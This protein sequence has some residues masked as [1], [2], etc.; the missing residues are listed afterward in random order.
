MGAKIFSIE[1]PDDAWPPQTQGGVI[2][3]PTRPTW[4]GSPTVPFRVR[5][6]GLFPGMMFTLQPPNETMCS[7]LW[8][9]NRNFSWV[10]APF[11]N[12]STSDGH[13]CPDG[14]CINV[15]DAPIPVYPTMTV[16][17]TLTTSETPTEEAT[18]TLSPTLS[19]TDTESQS[20]TASN[21]ISPTITHT[22]KPDEIK[23]EPP[24]YYGF[25]FGG[26]RAP[27]ATTD[28]NADGTEAIFHV[29]IS[30]YLEQSVTGLVFCFQPPQVSMTP[31]PLNPNR[32]DINFTMTESLWPPIV[33][34]TID[35][36]IELQLYEIRTISGPGGIRTFVNRTVGTKSSWKVANDQP[37]YSIEFGSTLDY[38]MTAYIPWGHLHAAFSLDPWCG[39]LVAP[40]GWDPPDGVSGSSW[41]DDPTLPKNTWGYGWAVDTMNISLTDPENGGDHVFTLRVTQPESVRWAVNTTLTLC[42]KPY[43]TWPYFHPVYFGED[44]DRGDREVVQF[45]LRAAVYTAFHLAEVLVP[46]YAPPLGYFGPTADTVHN[47]TV[48]MLVGKTYTINMIGEG[49]HS[50]MKMAINATCDGMGAPSSLNYG[51]SGGWVF[52]TS[53]VTLT[54]PTSDGAS[55]TFSPRRAGRD[56]RFCLSFVGPRAPA[57]YSMDLGF[58]VTVYRIFGINTPFNGVDHYRF[59][60]GTSAPQWLLS[61]HMEPHIRIKFEGG[62]GVGR[63]TGDETTIGDCTLD[64][65]GQHHPSYPYTAPSWYW[66]A[67]YP[68]PGYP[69]FMLNYSQTDRW[70]TNVFVCVATY[71]WS[72]SLYEIMPFRVNFTTT[73]RNASFLDR[74]VVPTEPFYVYQGYIFSIDFQ[75]DGIWPH[76]RLAVSEDI[77]GASSVFPCIGTLTF[78]EQTDATF[79]DYN[80]AERTFAQLT[81]PDEW[82]SGRTV[83]GWG[84]APSSCVPAY[85]CMSQF[86]SGNDFS[87]QTDW[88]L[89]VMRLVTIENQLHLN[90]A[91]G[92]SAKVFNI[93]HKC[94]GVGNEITFASDCSEVRKTCDGTTPV[95][96]E[97]CFAST[98]GDTLSTAKLQGCQLDR[99]GP[100]GYSE[101]LTIASPIQLPGTLF[102]VYHCQ[103]RRH[104]ILQKVCYSTY[105]GGVFRDTGLTANFEVIVR[106]MTI[107]TVQVLKGGEV[108]YL[109]GS[110]PTLKLAGEGLYKYMRLAAMPNCSADSGLDEMP[111]TYVMN[112][113]SGR[114]TNRSALEVMIPWTFVVNSDK[115][116]S[117]ELQ[118]TPPAVVTSRPLYRFQL[119]MSEFGAASERWLDFSIETGYWFTVVGL[120]SLNSTRYPRVSYGDRMLMTVQG[121]NMVRGMQV[122]FHPTDCSKTAPVTEVCDGTLGA[123]GATGCNA[124][125]DTLCYPVPTEGLQE[126]GLWFFLLQTMSGQH[127]L[128]LKVCVSVW[129]LP[130]QRFYDSGLKIDFFIN[131]QSAEAD[132]QVLK[133][134]D[135]VLVYKGYDEFP[136]ELPQNFPSGDTR[137]GRAAEIKLQG[138]GFRDTFRVKFQEECGVQNSSHG[139][140]PIVVRPA[141]DTQI[142]QRDETLCGLGD[143]VAFL[144]LQPEHVAVGTPNYEI[145]FS[146]LAQGTDFSARSYIFFGVVELKTIS[147]S[148]ASH[149]TL[150]YG[151]VGQ[152]VLYGS[153]LA[154]FMLWKIDSV[155]LPSPS[156]TTFECNSGK[157]DGFET[158]VSFLDTGGVPRC[159]PDPLGRCERYGGKFDRRF[160][161]GFGG[162][163]TIGHQHTFRQAENMPVCL[164]LWGKNEQTG[165]H[166]RFYRTEITFTNEIKVESIESYGKHHMAGSFY[167][168][169][170]YVYMRYPEHT[171]TLH[172]YGFYDHH[173]L[174]F[175]SGGCG[176]F[177][178]SK[179]SHLKL[180]PSNVLPVSL[181][182]NTTLFTTPQADGRMRV[183]ALVHFNVISNLTDLHACYSVFRENDP[184]NKNNFSLPLGIKLTTVDLSLQ[185]IVGV[186]WQMEKT[187]T[188][189]YGEPVLYQLGGNNLLA[190]SNTKNQFL[191]NFDSDCSSNVTLGVATPAT[192]IYRDTRDPLTQ[193]VI[194]SVPSFSLPTSATRQYST[195]RKLCFSPYKLPYQHFL[196]TGYRADF[197]CR[198][199]HLPC[200]DGTTGIC[201]VNATKYQQLVVGCSCTFDQRTNYSCTLPTQKT[202]NT[203]TTCS[204]HGGCSLTTDECF[205]D[206]GY[207]GPSCGWCQIEIGS[208]R[209]TDSL[210]HIVVTFNRGYTAKLEVASERELMGAKGLTCKHLLPHEEMIRFGHPECLW[211]APN[212]LHIFAGYG[213]DVPGVVQVNTEGINA[214]CAESGGGSSPRIIPF[215]HPTPRAVPVLLLPNVIG[216]CDGITFDA[217]LS[218][219]PAG[220]LAYSFRVENTTGSMWP[221]QLN[222]LLRDR[223]DDTVPTVHIPDAYFPQGV[224]EVILTVYSR[225]LGYSEDTVQVVEKC[226]SSTCALTGPNGPV[227]LVVT[228]PQPTEIAVPDVTSLIEI[229]PA[230]VS[231][232]ALVK[233]PEGSH[234]ITR[235]TGVRYETPVEKTYIYNWT[236][237]WRPQL[238][239]VYQ[240]EQDDGNIVDFVETSIIGDWKKVVVDPLTSSKPTLFFSIL[241]QTEAGLEA[242]I[243]MNRSAKANV[244][245]S[246]LADYKQA[247]FADEAIFAPD[248]GEPE[249]GQFWRRTVV[250]RGGAEVVLTR[251]PTILAYF[252]GGN[253]TV[254]RNFTMELVVR[255]GGRNGLDGLDPYV[256]EWWCNDTTNGLTT[257]HCDGG[258]CSDVRVPCPAPVVVQGSLAQAVQ[259]TF[260]PPWTVDLRVGKYLFTAVYH[261]SRLQMSGTAVAEIEVVSGLSTLDVGIVALNNTVQFQRFAHSQPIIVLPD[262]L[263]PKLLPTSSFRY[264]WSMRAGNR[265][266][267]FDTGVDPTSSLL[268]APPF[269]FLSGGSY[270]FQ[271]LVTEVDEKGVVLRQATPTFDFSCLT[272]PHGGRLAIGS[273]DENGQ[274]VLRAE[275]WTV[276]PDRLP[277]QFKFWTELLCEGARAEGCSC[278]FQGVRNN[279]ETACLKAC[280]S[281]SCGVLADFG[282]RPYLSVTVPATLRPQNVSYFLSARDLRGV[283]HE[284]YLK[285]PT[286]VKIVDPNEPSGGASTNCKLCDGQ[287]VCGAVRNEIDCQALEQLSWAVDRLDVSRFLLSYSELSSSMLVLVQKQ[288]V[289][290]VCPTQTRPL[291]L[292]PS[293]TR[294]T[295]TPTAWYNGSTPTIP[296]QVPTATVKPYEGSVDPGLLAS[297]TKPIPPPPR[298]P[299]GQTPTATMT[300]NVTSQTA[301]LRGVECRAVIPATDSIPLLP[302]FPKDWAMSYQVLQMARKAT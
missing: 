191:F 210:K 256:T 52:D 40:Y 272:P 125:S 299:P 203:S 159:Q 192:L 35:S 43:R 292:T 166:S 63:Y 260:G 80:N 1:S 70:Q 116:D 104:Q 212:I 86:S 87:F 182:D 73:F 50:W 158:P 45:T 95:T 254:A 135:T 161:G 184:V 237:W 232:Q 301:T 225:V 69:L 274:R 264:R 238:G 142:P 284:T 57:E 146:Q 240:V 98:A 38:A 194:P 267:P 120:L 141:E 27:V 61:E 64:E 66:D 279:V 114:A 247:E 268:V 163:V 150:P 270:Q 291:T 121:V 109:M 127:E 259:F 140:A 91:Y 90:V 3:I 131:V 205:C 83:D 245:V 6:E 249:A 233:Y 248:S 290:I 214:F 202:C 78:L 53:D 46:E 62:D 117:T 15:T 101:R 228:I 253:R 271:L 171:I 222:M 44:P 152:L 218:W 213:A 108:K 75:G 71:P 153:S 165:V 148:A 16:Q 2:R 12:Y 132:G 145:C 289:Q 208:A 48:R 227:R 119:C 5:G 294:T 28:V 169:D 175:M 68:G 21:T 110:R 204:G 111:A 20:D 177:N 199:T 275:G 164:S 88:R 123:I 89:K 252:R 13:P 278:C 197:R 51:S 174:A 195:D 97:D 126:P 33:D 79:F 115:T 215:P 216:P 172:G 286:G 67:Q 251:K 201:D 293:L 183:A 235:R 246:L 258:G 85:I 298:Y 206:P 55:V 76:M 72:H 113:G 11:V 134:Y 24:D 242:V 283:E 147:F 60:Y 149:A 8:N 193:K 180:G 262:I 244:T 196:D 219:G 263:S 42:A 234:C 105:P 265:P 130:A 200:S 49:L 185:Q 9:L 273:P 133:P 188:I 266:L 77:S 170:I 36:K 4:L 257:R 176:Q 155:A 241:R 82:V 198:S 287:K 30:P 102:F 99:L 156:G 34:F 19:L 261:N 84:A 124:L 224:Y 59:P 18:A 74:T 41:R 230:E 136:Y 17:A 276:E 229:G 94:G 93:I 26:I 10:A 295:V 100:G 282:Y 221:E 122:K 65:F 162:L 178:A 103:T 277:F 157:L 223:E 81:I 137:I 107:D 189:W 186:E 154:P 168:E 190:P 32:T 211:E 280:S 181:P 209:Y 22:K 231:G 37:P 288:F 29:P 281:C 236:V 179:P 239:D 151:F 285:V 160:D 106:S 269:T 96:S 144:D 143:R 58:S 129:P 14:G 226:S 7:Q 128:G 25:N 300:K 31:R 112:D 173:R 255:A 220:E 139:G 243:P 118:F 138:I 250:A 92:A 39:K 47:S 54:N 167:H 296:L 217:S 187:L 207:Y 297:M 56:L 302:F 23:K